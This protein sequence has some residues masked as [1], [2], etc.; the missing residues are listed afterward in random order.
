MADRMALYK[1]NLLLL[2]N[3]EPIF[4]Y[5]LS[6]VWIFNK[7]KNRSILTVI[8]APCPQSCM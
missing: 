7:L 1:F 2:L 8:F 3:Y 4:V 5:R 6:Y